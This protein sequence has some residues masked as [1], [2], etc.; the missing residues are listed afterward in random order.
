MDIQT[1]LKI[2]N[3]IIGGANIASGVGLSNLGNIVI[4]DEN[5]DTNSSPLVNDFLNSPFDGEF[6]NK[7]KKVMAAA[8]AIADIKNG[9]PLGNPFEIASSADDAVEQSKITFK[10]SHGLTTVEEACD[11][12]IDNAAARVIANVDTVVDSGVDFITTKIATAVSAA[13]P[14]A[15]PVVQMASAVLQR[16]KPIIKKAIKSFIPKVQEMAKKVCHS[17]I[18]KGR[19]LI[20]RIFA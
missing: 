19:S 20:R 14:A 12:M 10:L 4:Q 8:K 9:A 7:V 16:S 5:N 11:R 13:F 1:G 17:V 18:E 6:D 15:A 2:A 3:D